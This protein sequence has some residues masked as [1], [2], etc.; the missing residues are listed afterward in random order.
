MIDLAEDSQRGGLNRTG[1]DFASHTIR[2]VMIATKAR[3]WSSAVLFVDLVTAFDSV[4]RE[5]I[6]GGKMAPDR[7]RVNLAKLGLDADIIEAVESYAAHEDILMRVH[8]PEEPR[9][10]Q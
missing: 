8:V 1:S 5:I 10:L 7:L 9:P 2:Q 3:S 6:M 4:I